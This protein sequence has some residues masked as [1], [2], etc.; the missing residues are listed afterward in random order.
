M[1]CVNRVNIEGALF[2]SWRSAPALISICFTSKK[3]CFTTF[4]EEGGGRDADIVVYCI[5]YSA[6]ACG[7]RKE[8]RQGKTR[9]TR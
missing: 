2:G 5:K 3:G 6:V 7:M 9:E 1:G 4:S 8:L